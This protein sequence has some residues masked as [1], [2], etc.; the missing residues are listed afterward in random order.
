VT[1]TQ[2]DPE[3]EHEFYHHRLEDGGRKMRMHMQK[4]LFTTSV[5][6]LIAPISTP[7][8]IRSDECTSGRQVWTRHDGVHV[9]MYVGCIINFQ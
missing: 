5:V 7:V 4:R 3:D 8:V 6:Y 9:C 2:D 1:T